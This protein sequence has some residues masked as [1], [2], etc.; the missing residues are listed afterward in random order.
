MT[1]H[2]ATRHM[3][4]KHLV[5]WLVSSW[6]VMS[7]EDFHVGAFC[8]KKLGILESF[9][10][11]VSIN[12]FEFFCVSAHTFRCT[13]NIFSSTSQLRVKAH[14]VKG[15]WICVDT[16]ASMSWVDNVIIFVRQTV[17]RIRSGKWKNRNIFKKYQFVSVHFVIP[18]AQTVLHRGEITRCFPNNRSI[19]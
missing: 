6:L 12:S 3:H 7:Y 11:H 10:F 19:N 4:N 1:D 5:T 14:Q 13:Q 16:W 2:F 8:S 17:N 15:R 18:L 9:M